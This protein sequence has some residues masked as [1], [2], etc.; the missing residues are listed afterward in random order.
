MR[1]RPLVERTTINAVWHICAF[2]WTAI[3]GLVT[4]RVV[5]N[6]LGLPQF[7]LFGI[8]SVFLAPLALTNLG[9]GEATVKYVAEHANAGDFKAAI[10]YLQ[11]SMLMSLCTGILGALILAFCGP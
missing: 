2:L 6:A 9:F 4:I 3:V 5:V 10:P 11:T 8:F 7:G 1:A